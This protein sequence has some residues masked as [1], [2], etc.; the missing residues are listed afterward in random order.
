[1]PSELRLIAR[2]R[3]LKSCLFALVFLHLVSGISPAAKP[4][5]PGFERF[6]RDAKTNAAAGGRLLLGELN[7]TSCHIADA[8]LEKSL[9]KKQAPVLDGVGT[10]VSLDY[11]RKFLADPHAVKPGTTMPRLFAGLPDSERK[12]RVEALV[13]FLAS[14]GTFRHTLPNAAAAPTGEKLFHT[15]GCVACHGPRSKGARKST[16]NLNGLAIVPLGDPGKKYNVR[17]LADYLRDP[18]KTRPAGRMPGL[19]LSRKEAEAIA[20]WFLKDVQ[21]PSN[22][23]FKYYEGRWGNLP[24]FAK[25]KPKA[26]GG[27][28]GFD[29]R[30]ARRN[31]NYAIR[32]EGWVQIATAGEYTFHLASDDGSKLFLDGKLVVNND[33]EHAVVQK[34]GK[35]TLKP[36]PHKL[37]VDFAQLGGG[38]ELRVE[39]EG[40][41]IRRR[42]LASAVTSTRE[43]PKPKDGFKLNPELVSKGRELFSSVGC[44]SCHQLKLD[45]KTVASTLRAKPLADLSWGRGCATNLPAKPQAVAFDLSDR[46]HRAVQSA[47]RTKPRVAQPETAIHN[48][49]VAMNCYACHSRGKTGG[50]LEELDAQFVTTIKEMGEEGRIPPPLDGVGDKLTD[51][52]LKHVLANGANDR[53]YMLTRMPKF[54]EKNVGHLATLYAEVDRKSLVAKPKPSTTLPRLK[55]AGRKLVGE[56]SFACIKCHTWDK[57]EATGI[58]SLD[59]TKMTKRIRRDWF[60]RYMMNP[61]RYRPGTRMPT[62]F[63]GGISTLPDVLSGKPDEQLLAMWTF[64]ADGTKARTPSGLIRGQIELKPKNEPIIYRNFIQGLSPRGIAVGYPGGLNLAFD[65]ERMVLALLWHGPFIDAAKHWRGRGQGFQG[66]LG[67]H[68]LPLPREIPFARLESKDSA[69]PT[70]SAKDAGYKFL[71][72]RLNKKRQP[73]FR[74]RLNGIEIEDHPQPVKGVIDPSLKRTLTLK[75]KKPRAASGRLWFRAATASKEI[76]PLKDG[77]YKI[78][79]LMRVRVSSGTNKPIVRKNGNRHE[80]LM[81]VQFD[82]NGAKLTQEIAW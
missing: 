19:D 41:G 63:P 35:V 56:K 44:A 14:T 36:G 51:A 40:P 68:L 64:I 80:L 28:A 34:S 59:L 50:P 10:R 67:D 6:H 79:N 78:D 82:K 7:C 29:I 46:Q 2:S 72:Y 30:L 75:S 20:S 53:P 69:W 22:L 58:Q 60:F 54:G 55:A 81:P 57:Y 8:A 24:D 65:A 11:L 62:P 12:S 71:G 76:K 26:S 43:P 37:I 49:M 33:G 1:M 48:T 32:F 31:S 18:L 74:Y 27:A 73:V 42:N 5:V 45:G 4:V 66:P 61:I 17:S 25:L 15:V 3:R 23:T 70:T 9:R 77:W 38:A 39:Y 47:V 16:G 21:V 52:W 13:H